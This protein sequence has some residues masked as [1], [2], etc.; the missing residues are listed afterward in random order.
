MKIG[1][2]GYGTVGKGVCDILSKENS[3]QQIVKILR[4]KENV[5]AGDELFTSD[6]DEILFDKDIDLVVEV[7]GGSEP[8]LSY[9]KTA[10]K[11]G[12]HVVTANKQIVADN[13][14]ELHALARECGVGF[15]YEASCGGG[16]PFVKT[17][18][19]L[20]SFEE[21]SRVSGIL[22]GS[23]N[24]ILTLME[25]GQSFDEAVLS[26]RENGF[27]EADCTADLG[28]ADPAR[29]LAIISSLAY[30]CYVPT[31]SI[32]TRGLYG[33]RAEFMAFLREKGFVL[34]FLASSE[35][36]E[37]KIFASVR[38]V[39]VSKKSPFAGVLSEYNGVEIYAENSGRLFFSGK[40]AGRYPTG[41]AVVGDITE[42]SR[43]YKGIPYFPADRQYDVIMRE[44]GDFFV[45]I[46]GGT[47]KKACGVTDAEADALGFAARIIY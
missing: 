11:N 47:F 40:G 30:H 45:D 23:T 24:Y 34:K 13:F 25:G 46:A 33:V 44:K 14:S 16:I 20:A 39:A 15:S 19:N 41:A 9:V 10:M 31:D 17:V 12:K 7:L 2:L 18:A 29:K 37:G 42:I 3:G 8:A 1:L 5:P 35:M 27:L 26:A 36:R 32:Y 22:N 6:A 38:P 28:G 43:G 4:R 21:I